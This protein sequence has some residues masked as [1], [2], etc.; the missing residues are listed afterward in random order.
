[1]TLAGELLDV[2]DHGPSAA[3]IDAGLWQA[4]TDI[5]LAQAIYLGSADARTLD[6]SR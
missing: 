6:Q 1:M 4:L 5:S 3:A 2:V